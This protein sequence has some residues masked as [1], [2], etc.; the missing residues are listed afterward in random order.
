MLAEP[1]GQGLL[2]Y[3]FV[4]LRKLFSQAILFAHAFDLRNGLWR[5]LLLDSFLVAAINFDFFS[6]FDHHLVV[7]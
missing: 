1:L 7:V 3:R 6:D 5:L 4:N 2:K